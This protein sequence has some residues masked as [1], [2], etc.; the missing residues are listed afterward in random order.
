MF[1]APLIRALRRPIDPKWQTRRPIFK[2]GDPDNHMVWRCWDHETKTHHWQDGDDPLKCPW[3]IGTQIYAK[4]TWALGVDAWGSDTIF[5]RADGDVATVQFP[6]RPARGKWRSSMMMP[7]WVARIHREITGIRAERVN[8]ITF[9]DAVAEGI[10]E[11]GHEFDLDT[12]Y[13]VDLWRNRTTVE[14]FAWLWDGINGAGDCDRGAWV[15]VLELGPLKNGG[16]AS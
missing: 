5:Y 9:V 6:N 10:S 1:K 2:D 16:H 4:E 8:Q 3:S 7:R 13:D 15:W 12:E 14:N 11:Y